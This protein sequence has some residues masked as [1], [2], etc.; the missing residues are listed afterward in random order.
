MGGGD[1]VELSRL[2]VK[3]SI[4]LGHNRECNDVLLSG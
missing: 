3:V 4:I 2:E 1:F